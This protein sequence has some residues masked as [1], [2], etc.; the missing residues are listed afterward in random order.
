MG[1]PQSR[2]PMGL[3]LSNCL[4]SDNSTDDDMNEGPSVAR[5]PK[6]AEPSPALLEWYGYATVDE[7]LE[8]TFFDSTDNDTTDNS[9][10]DDYTRDVSYSSKSKSEGKCLP[11]G[12]KAS[13][14]VIKNKN[15]E[16][17]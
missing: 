1:R 5:V 8:N 2:S 13:H 14:K 7:Y 15:V 17:T 4:S 6:E 16:D 11:V 12:K 9:I 10:K 3:L